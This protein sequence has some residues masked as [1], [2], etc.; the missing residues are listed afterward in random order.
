MHD[1]IVIARRRPGL[2][3]RMAE[4]HGLF[5]LWRER[6]RGRRQLLALDTRMLRDIGLSRV[7]ATAEA[8][9]PFWVA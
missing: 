9:K 5:A 4:L 1:S 7:D 2:S 3:A 8:G 6:R